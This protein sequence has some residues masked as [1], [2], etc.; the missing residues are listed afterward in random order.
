MT[1]LQ[2]LLIL[3]TLLPSLAAA[4]GPVAPVAAPLR[5][6]LVMPPAVRHLLHNLHL[7]DL[8]PEWRRK[9]WIGNRRQGSCVHAAMVHLLH[10]QGEHAAA[11]RW[12]QSH[13]NGET[14]EGLAVKLEAA[15]IR[16]AETRTGD[17]SF[18]AWAIRTRRGAGVV[19]QNGSHMVNLVG[20]DQTTATI[21]DSNSPDQLRTQPRAEFLREWKQS[22]GWAVTPVATPNAPDPWIVKSSNSVKRKT[23]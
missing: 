6:L 7:V 9:N 3:S 2:R 14:A 16:F 17:E 15:G 4:A 13:A 10:W 8:P 11:D 5:P 19:V 12:Q 1:P 21:L 20:L 23:P 22:G 18:L